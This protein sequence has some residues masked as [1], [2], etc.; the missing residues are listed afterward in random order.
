MDKIPNTLAEL[1]EVL[2]KN[3]ANANPATQRGFRNPVVSSINLIGL[4]VQ[5]NDVIS[6][7]DALTILHTF[8]QLKEAG[9]QFDLNMT[10]NAYDL[11]VREPS[12]KVFKFGD[13][14]AQV[15]IKK[16]FLETPATGDLAILLGL[17]PEEFDP[18]QNVGTAGT[19]PVPD[20]ATK[21]LWTATFDMPTTDTKIIASR[22]SGVSIDEWVGHKFPIRIKPGEYESKIT[23]S[24]RCLEFAFHHKTIEELIAA[25]NLT[26]GSSD[27]G[28][29]IHGR[30]EDFR[31][32]KGLAYD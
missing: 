29:L 16:N 17:S 2:V 9:F 25:G 10:F 4:P 23:P 32:Q 18:E 15:N 1:I 20:M 8:E 21:E 5:D 31:Q 22:N 26:T 13:K 11:S 14:E 27:F 7:G 12:H 30:Y 19:R 24:D 3:Y 6:T 28:R